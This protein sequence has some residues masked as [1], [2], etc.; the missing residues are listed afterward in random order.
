[1]G[2]GAGWQATNVDSVCAA[3]TKCHSCQFSIVTSNFPA[4][5]KSQIRFVH[6]LTYTKASAISFSL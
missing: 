4:F 6:E 5:L 3:H 1:M 2:M